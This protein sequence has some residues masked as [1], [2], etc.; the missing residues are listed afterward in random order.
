MS[1]SFSVALHHSD[2]RGN[3]CTQRDTR[4]L[5]RR[6][7][8]DIVA[9]LD[10]A[11][12]IIR[13]MTM[14][15]SARVRVADSSNREH[16]GDV[17]VEKLPDGVRMTLQ[18]DGLGPWSAPGEDYFDALC[19]LRLELEAAGL[20][21]CVTGARVDAH[22]SGLSRDMGGG[23]MVYLLRRRRLAD[24]LLGRRRGRTGRLVDLLSPAPCELVG[25][26]AEQR[27]FFENWWN[28]FA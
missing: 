23:Q 12:G 13:T 9:L 2:M 1:T 14:D 5:D 27:E 25:T 6:V 7:S 19:N 18:A 10:R 3:G 28:G 17:T 16:V 8:P 4:R 22:P 26:V 15:D 20:R 21:I 11:V 24:R